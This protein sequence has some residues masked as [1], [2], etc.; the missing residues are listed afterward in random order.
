M[1]IV[2]MPDGQKVKFPDD[3][4]KEEIRGLIASKFPSVGQQQARELPQQ[5]IKPSMGKTV[6]D[7]GLQGATF[8][9]ADEAI[10][11]LSAVYAT[12]RMEPKA[13]FTGEVTNPALI[14]QLSNVRQR[15]QH[16]L[17]QQQEQRPVT[18][19]VAGIG[20]AL[21][22][23]GAG[24]T[25]KTGS[26][27]GNLL[28]TGNLASKTA[29]GVVA[30][31]PLGVLY[32]YGQG[33]DG[34]RGESA[35]EAGFYSAL[36]GGAMPVAGAAIKTAGKAIIPKVDENL[37]DIAKLAVEK[38]KI[39]LSID[40]ITGSKPWKNIQKLSQEIPASGY[41]NFRDKQL[42]Q[43]NKALLTTTGVDADSFSPVVMDRAFMNVGKKFDDFG[44]NK[45][46][47]ANKIYNK[48]QTILQ[49]SEQFATDEAKNILIKN[50]DS[51]IENT[52]GNGSIS[53]VKLNQIRTRINRNARKAKDND[54]K[55]LLR[56]LEN[57][58]IDTMTD[59]ADEAMKQAKQQYKNLLV[60]EPLTAKSA[61]GNISPTA[62]NQRVYSI[63]GRSFVRGKAG[64]IGD[65]AR[66]G[67]ELLPELGGSDTTQKILYS[68][69]ITAGVV[70]P[71]T[72]AVTGSL[73]GGNRAMQS[74][75]NRNQGI[76][77]KMTAEQKKELMALP[78]AEA[79]KVLDA[80][81]FMTYQQTGT[82]G[83]GQ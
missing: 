78:P 32:G 22:T 16:E 82:M 61:G 48:T 50:L 31:A 5:E 17:Q 75:I 41:K 34:K 71:S 53:G 80:L 20:G 65:L 63:Y 81:K 28:R 36:A 56:D 58:I 62:L 60:L 4:S 15:S 79:R 19:A 64:E 24:A 69:G 29:K 26:A 21:L 57:A 9:F 38:Y 44:K 54:T 1:P 59:G 67:K 42:K 73:M 33:E 14:E 30:S 77:R 12:A 43:W 6:L 46:F 45:T 70:Q 55:E 27:L 76:I 8:G 37:R 51:I 52:S 7:Q 3:M 72:L 83:G 23:G 25:T 66:I 47:D 11:P 74:L 13:L 10:D 68:S 49:D 18:S 35:R 40:Q 2:Q 39:P